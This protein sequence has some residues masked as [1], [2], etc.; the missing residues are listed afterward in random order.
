M[1]VEQQY[2]R[3]TIIIKDGEPIHLQYGM[4]SGGRAG[5]E[6]SSG[7][8][9]PIPIGTSPIVLIHQGFTRVITL[10]SDSPTQNVTGLIGFQELLV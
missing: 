9:A 5:T 3:S 4:D 2:Y 7:R 8:G 10:G 1:S 6:V